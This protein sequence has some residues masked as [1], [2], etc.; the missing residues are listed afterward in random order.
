L[1]K[2]LEYA[3]IVTS[4][5]VKIVITISQKEKWRN[6]INMQKFK[7]IK[8]ADLV[9]ITIDYSREQFLENYNS[10]EGEEL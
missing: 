4:N 10:E 3:R 8:E 6:M 2:R 9:G 1:K 7:E 5:P